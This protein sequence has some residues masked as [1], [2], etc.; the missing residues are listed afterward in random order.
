MRCAYEGQP[1]RCQGHEAQGTQREVIY[2]WSPPVC[3][4]K[5]RIFRLVTLGPDFRLAVAEAN[6]WN[7]K[8]DEYRLSVHGQKPRLDNVR[9][10]SAADVVRKYESSPRFAL[11]RE[12]TR[13]DYAS[14]YR[15]LETFR[16]DGRRM[17]G[18]VNVSKITRKM[19]YGTY[20]HYVTAAGYESANKMMTAWQAAFKYAVLKIPGVT[21]NPFTQLDKHRP[22]PRRHRWTDEQLECF[23]RTAEAMGYAAVAR[24][25]LMC[26]ELV[27]R[28]GDILKLTWGSYRERE[29]AWYIHQS[30]KGAEVLVPPTKRLRAVLDAARIQAEVKAQGRPIAAVPICP[31]AT[32][33]HWDRHYLTRTAR[34]IAKRAGLPDDLQLRDLRRTGATEGAS[35]GATAWELMAVGGWQSQSSIR[36]YLVGTLEQAAA[37]QA[38]RDAYRDRHY[39]PHY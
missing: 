23:I 28:P 19:V 32:G 29:G 21:I 6:E 8:L 11:Y 3:L 20:E 38:K 16:F 37:C 10:M 4:R 2:Y 18:D 31:T 7:K 13:Q 34:R 9:P 27:Q 22:P 25:A 26:A 5:A 17:F 39:R 1:F 12:R 30:K 35:A 36:P 24:C 14:S 15:R 33:R